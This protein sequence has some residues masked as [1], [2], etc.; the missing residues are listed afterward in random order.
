[1]HLWLERK[2]RWQAGLSGE[3]RAY[4]EWRV[5]AGRDSAPLLVE[6]LRAA[7]DV[8]ARLTRLAADDLFTALILGGNLA[9]LMREITGRA[10]ERVRAERLLG[11]APDSGVG[12]TRSSGNRRDRRRPGRDLCGRIHPSTRAECALPDTHY[13]H[14]HR[15]LTDE[16]WHDALC[17]T[18]HGN[19]GEDGVACDTCNGGGFSLITLGDD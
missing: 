18:C 11:H 1:M 10:L 16:S 7:D 12:E 15:S 3:E 6:D 2:Q 8:R 13:P 4:L 17:V 14:P 9:E 19:G 5:H